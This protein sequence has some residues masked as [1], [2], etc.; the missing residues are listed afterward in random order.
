MRHT[1]HLAAVAAFSL[2]CDVAQLAA[3]EIL[4]PPQYDQVG[5]FNEGLAPVRTGKLWGFINR[6]NKTIVPFEYDEIRRG[7]DGRFGVK[8]GGQWG[9]I[10]SAGEIVIPL[11]YD[12]IGVFKDG[13]APASKN[14]KWGFITALGVVE[15][16][17]QFDQIGQREGNVF[18][19]LG[20]S[21]NAKQGTWRVMLASPGLEPV[22]I[23]DNAEVHVYD[24]GF[25]N[26]D[27]VTGF[28]EGVAVASFKAGKAQVMNV[29]WQGIEVRTNRNRFYHSIRPKR[30]GWAAAT[31][32]GKSWGYIDENGA[33][34]EPGS[35]QGARDFSMGVAPI[36]IDGKW[37]YMTKQRKYAFRP[38]YDRA[39]SFHE[40]YAT[41]RIGQKRGF[42]KLENGRIQEY[43]PP[44][45]ED[46]FRFQEGIAPIKLNG[47][48]GFLSNGKIPTSGTKRSIIDVLPE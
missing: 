27:T 2:I 10:N 20:G 33:F 22:A 39:Y 3:Q 31:L 47:K 48:W 35:L 6:E 23:H 11:Q 37:G 30:E 5:H 36:K 15:T 43:V 17:F 18:P 46:V 16:S 21:G 13:V 4:I 34:W 19:A 1:L 28:S 7:R 24:G 25:K 32:N 26:A 42:L 12:D 9:V 38:K 29:P 8:K 41:M 44:K 14:G 40:G 45:Y